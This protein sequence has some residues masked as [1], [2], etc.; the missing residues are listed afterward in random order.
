MLLFW[1]QQT[2]IKCG[3]YIFLHRT[4]RIGQ[5]AYYTPINKLRTLGLM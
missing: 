1:S 5:R 4:I 3:T 2:S